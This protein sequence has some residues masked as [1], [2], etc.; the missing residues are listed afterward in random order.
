MTIVS[1]GNVGIGTGTASPG[2]KLDVSGDIRANNAWLRT[3]GQ[4][5]WY[6]DT[7]FTGIYA[8]GANALSTTNAIIFNMT[9]ISCTSITT[10]NYNINAGT[11]TVFARK[12][13]FGNNPGGGGADN[14][15]INYYVRS[16]ED[17]TLEIGIQNDG[18][19][20]IALMPSGNVGIGTASPS[21][22]LD[23]AGNIRATGTIYGYDITA[24]SDI[25][26][27]KDIEPIKNSLE[28][29]NKL[30]GTYFKLIDSI[31][32]KRKMGLIAQ[33]VKKI[34]PEVVFEDKEG[35]LSISYGSLV[36]LL[37]ES[38]KELKSEIDNLKSKLNL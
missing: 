23:V 33:D 35:F 15:Y 6:N 8:S 18:T 29:V 16:G 25:R 3:T 13:D 37:I 30:D 10:N 27:K 36:A 7:H 12:I 19:D 22:K 9:E 24:T 28:M 11:G 5:G 14:A 2:Y 20:H 34:V 38:T 32:N 17:C 26:K 21:Y 31:N 4:T 1:N